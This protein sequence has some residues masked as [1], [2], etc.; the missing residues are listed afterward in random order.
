MHFGLKRWI[1]ESQKKG[2]IGD[3][4]QHVD[5]IRI[6][7]EHAESKGIEIVLENLNSYWT[8][9]GISDETPYV[10][11]DWTTKNE[12]FGMCPEE[13]IQM[14]L[15]VDRVNVKLCLDTSHVCTYAHRFPED[16]REERISKF[17]DKPELIKHVHWSDNY[18]YDIRGRSDSHLSVGKGTIPTTFHQR[19]KQLDATILL[20]HFHGLEELEV[21]L[22]HISDL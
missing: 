21:E 18:L 20:E 8:Q 12:A 7:A 14:C 10:D 13:W 22:D 11:V 19:I 9:N 4:G 5:A 15:D 2:Q 3:Y 17:L 1:D 16:Q 6:I